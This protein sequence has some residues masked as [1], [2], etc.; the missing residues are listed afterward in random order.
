MRVTDAAEAAGRT[1]APLLA[2][3]AS[4][5]GWGSEQAAVAEGV[6]AHQDRCGGSSRPNGLGSG[7]RTAR[8]GRRGSRRVVAGSVGRVGEEGKGERERW[9]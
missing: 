3:L 8:G 5:Y 7:G 6:L 2:S 4:A 9:T 1:T